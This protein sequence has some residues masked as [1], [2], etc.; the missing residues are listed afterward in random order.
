MR[1]I[2]I[3]RFKDFLVENLQQAEKNYFSS[4]K[5]TPEQKEEVL[6]VTHGDVYTNFIASVAE[7]KNEHGWMSIISRYALD[8]FYDAI[9]NYNKNIFPI[10]DINNDLT[11]VVCDYDIFNAFV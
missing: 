7:F 10:N 2:K 3:D 8:F 11:Q 4:G 6:A 1:R 5:L 9:K